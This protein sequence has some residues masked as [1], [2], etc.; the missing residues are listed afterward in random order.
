MTQETYEINSATK[1]TRSAPPIRIHIPFMPR[2]APLL[3]RQQRAPFGCH[4]HASICEQRRQIYEGSG[5]FVVGTNRRVGQKLVR[6]APVECMCP[7]HA[8]VHLW[9]SVTTCVGVSGVTQN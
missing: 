3:V 7:V 4:G 2:I 1:C 8:S 6:N 5:G 9:A